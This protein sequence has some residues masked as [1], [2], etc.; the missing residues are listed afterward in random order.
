MLGKRWRGSLTGVSVRGRHETDSDSSVQGKSVWKW[1]GD[2]YAFPFGLTQLV[3]VC[4]AL[5][6]VI[7]PNL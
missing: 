6:K 4:S 3:R 2:L 5:G 1:R 7:L